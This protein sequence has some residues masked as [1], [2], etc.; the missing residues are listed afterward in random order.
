MAAAARSGVASRRAGRPSASLN[1]SFA[2]G[3]AVGISPFGY[4]RNGW[5]GHTGNTTPSH[6]DVELIKIYF[7]IHKSYR[8]TPK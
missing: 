7:L 1:N 6:E 2:F 3:N 5:S 4:I 8:N